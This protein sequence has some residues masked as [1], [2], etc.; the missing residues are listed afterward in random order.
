MAITIKNPRVDLLVREL[1]EITGETKT[2]AIERALEE[3]KSRLSLGVS[4]SSR[5][6]RIGRFLTEEVWPRV[7]ADQLGRKLSKE[8]EEA[9]LGYGKH[10]V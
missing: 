9:I 3:R 6:E 7:P 5:A 10:G 2:L 1:V 8:D 4:M